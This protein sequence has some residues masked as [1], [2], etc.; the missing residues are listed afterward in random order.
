MHLLEHAPGIEKPNRP[1]GQQ[2]GAFH[3]PF[4]VPTALKIRR[5]PD[6]FRCRV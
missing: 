5:R 4:D 1:G 6:R 3:L 2:T